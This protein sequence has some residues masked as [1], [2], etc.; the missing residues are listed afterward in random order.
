MPISYFLLSW[1]EH[2]GLFDLKI[3][4]ET[5]NI[6]ARI[7]IPWTA[8]FLNAEVLPPHDIQIEYFPSIILNCA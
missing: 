7:R 2:F 4:S 3:N 6:L 1:I 5:A 8:N